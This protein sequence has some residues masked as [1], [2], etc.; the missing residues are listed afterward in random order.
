M[1]INFPD[2][3]ATNDTYVSPTGLQYIYDGTKWRSFKPTE[4]IVGTFNANS[5]I[6]L[7]AG[8]TNQNITLTPSG[9]GVVYLPS[10]VGIG[11]STPTTKLQVNGS[12]AATTKSFIIK[13]PTK[14]GMQLRHGSLEGPENG[15]Y[16][17]G[18]LKGSNIIEL[19]D[20]WI[21]LVHEDS[22]T[23]TLTP[24]GRNQNI[25]IDSIENNRVIVSGDSIDC[26]YFIMAER[27][28]VERFDVEF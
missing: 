22:I 7:S 5:A 18:R 26:Y 13:H 27:K 21:G 17:R 20:Y 28:D 14:E 11:T 23:A 8:G 1:A 19:P 15:V 12:F 2:S 10:S 16:V 3:P 24:I 4:A 6:S 9:T 25:W